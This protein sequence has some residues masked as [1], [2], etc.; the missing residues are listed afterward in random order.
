MYKTRSV[1]SSQLH[2]Y[3]LCHFFTKRLVQ[4]RVDLAVVDK[5]V[6]GIKVDLESPA[7]CRAR[8]LSKFYMTYSL[9]YT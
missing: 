5:N 9:I 8:G 6:P 4:Y 1:F 3:A 2:V 7:S